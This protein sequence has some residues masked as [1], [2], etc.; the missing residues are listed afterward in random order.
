LPE[1]NVLLAGFGLFPS[2]KADSLPA[3][4]L[5]TSGSVTVGFTP[6]TF[7]FADLT[8]PEGVAAEAFGSLIYSLEVSGPSTVPVTIDI[9]VRRWLRLAGSSRTGSIPPVSE[10]T[11]RLT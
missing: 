11:P 3:Y 7:L 2:A 6:D 8:V 9:T 1:R 4:I 10:S 5:N